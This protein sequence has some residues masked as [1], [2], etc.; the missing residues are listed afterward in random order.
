MIDNPK[1][2]LGLLL[3]IT[4]VFLFYAALFPFQDW[5]LPSESI[6]NIVMYGWIDQIFIFDIVQNLLFFL[7]FGFFAAGYII[8]QNRRLFIAL[9]L[10]TIASFC[11]S[12]CIEILQ[13]YNPER[14]PSFLDV[15]LNTISGL[16]GALLSLFLMPY[17]PKLIQQIKVSVQ[18][19]NN[20]QN[21]WPY[22]GLMTWLG[23][24][25]YQL[26]PFIP[27]L[28]PKQLFEGILP[29]YLFFKKEMA[30]HPERFFF[31]SLQGT[32]LYFSGKLLLEDF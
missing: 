1:S 13:A 23:W 15:S 11:L 28:H 19:G 17:Y 25:C 30:F 20:K 24:A 29:V 31:Y 9:L 18:I 27:T 6:F 26:F 16:L 7:P 22:L 5:R 12:L 10:P 32:L 8:L 21:L 2:H 3:L 14:L 4:I